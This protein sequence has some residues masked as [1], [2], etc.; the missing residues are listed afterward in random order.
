MREICA[1]PQHI[2]WPMGAVKVRRLFLVTA[3]QGY[4]TA[5]ETLFAFVGFVGGEEMS[6]WSWMGLRQE[7]PAVNKLW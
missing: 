4:I 2:L 5:G 7:T 6:N 1:C 3:K